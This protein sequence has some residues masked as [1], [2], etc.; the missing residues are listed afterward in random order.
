MLA[1]GKFTGRSGPR[2]RRRADA[3]GSASPTPSAR[4][5]DYPHAFSG[6][7]R[8]RVMIAMALAN[9]PD[10]IIADEPTTALDVTIQAQILELLG[11]LNRDLGTAI[12][13]IT[14]NLGVVARSCQRVAVMYGGRI[15]EQAPRRRAVRPAPAPVHAGPARRHP[16]PGR[17]PRRPLVPIEGRPPDLIAP[18]PGCAY[19]PRCDAAQERCHDEQPPT[20]DDG[21]RAS[22]ECWVAGTDGELPPRPRDRGRRTRHRPR[23]SDGAAALGRPTWS[24]PSRSSGAPACCAGRRRGARRRRRRPSRIAPGR[25]ARAGRRVRLRQV[26]RGPGAAR[27]PS[28]DLGHDRRSTAR[29]S[30]SLRGRGAAPVPQPGPA[31]LPG[32]DV[33][34]QPAPHR[35]RRD[36]RA[37]A[38]ARPGARSAADQRRSPSCSSS[39]ASTRRRRRATRTSSPAASGSGS[40]I[41]RAL[42][43]NPRLLVCDEAVSALDVSLQAQIVN[44]LQR[45]A[46]RPRAGLPLHRPRPGHRP[47]HLATAS[48]S[49]TS[50]RSS[51]PARP[52]ALTANP[53]HPYTASL[54]SAV[55][56]PDPAREAHPRTHRAH[57][58][59]AEP[60]QPAPGLPL[61]H[62]LPD[63]TAARTPTGP[64]APPQA[65]PL[66]EV[67]PGPVRRLPL[68]RASSAA[69]GWATDRR[70]CRPGRPS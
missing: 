34:A 13:L 54:L 10:V 63:R 40:C 50:A 70:P 47:A 18:I 24:R 44:L 68:P 33:V 55:P 25:D 17:G 3:T 27:H 53:Q 14:H 51:S 37:A 48:W 62:P 1:H 46:A 66:R 5:A 15:V 20:Y 26:D 56:E 65:P 32:P 52:S 45:P 2:P 4:L 60:A 69:A 9:E 67:A 12:V 39:S 8:Q 7:M 6:G 11:E 29:T 59:R 28:A 35:R 41:A 21:A 36:R 22:W 19:A 43:V 42:A 57:R 58:R 23:P 49:C 31:G 38:R 61:P 30:G 64:S 16:A